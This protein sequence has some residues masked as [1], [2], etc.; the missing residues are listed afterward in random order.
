[1]EN[2]HF[3][4]IVAGENPDE[5]IK[6][7]DSK[8]KVEPH[9]LYEFKNAENMRKTAISALEIMLNK[10]V[11][12]AYDNIKKR[13]DEIKSMDATDYFLEVSNDYDVD[14]ETGNIVT[15][16]NPNGKYDACEPAKRWAVPMK[17]LDG[18]EVFSALKKDVDWQKTHLY[19]QYPYEFVWDSIVAETVKPS[20]P[21]EETLYNNMKNRRAYFDNFSDK[22]T[23]VVSNTSFWGYAFLSE[24]EGWK[25]LD[26]TTNQFDWVINFFDRFIA[27]LDDSEKI[28]IYECIRF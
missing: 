26:Y 7:Y 19:N 15:D 11:G 16:E 20:T 18:K 24:K 21:E 10:A 22:K 12:V 17:S 25:E 28:S 23:Y 13:L 5:L 4:L 3:V 14:E 27:P 8:L 2:R 1:M 6:K 9:V